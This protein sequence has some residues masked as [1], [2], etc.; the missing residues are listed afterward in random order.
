MWDSCDLHVKGRRHSSFCSYDTST[1]PPC[2]SSHSMLPFDPQSGWCDVQGRRAR[3]EDYHSIVFQEDYKFYGVFDGHCGSR[4]A[5]YASRALQV[6]IELLLNK[7]K[8]GSAMASPGGGMEESMEGS[9]SGDGV[10]EGSGA[11]SGVVRVLG[12]WA[13]TGEGGDPRTPATGGG[14]WGGLGQGQ[15]GTLQ[16]TATGSGPEVGAGDGIGDGAGAGAGDG[17][18]VGVPERAVIEHAIREAFRKTQREFIGT[19]SR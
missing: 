12:A 2:I 8:E 11:G 6:N 5:K 14:D 16:W 18:G 7:A 3:I 17:V 15:E 13:G 1:L 19:V 9:G 4:A 10:Q